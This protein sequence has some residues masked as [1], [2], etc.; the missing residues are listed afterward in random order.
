MMMRVKKTARGLVLSL[1][2]L[3]LT[4]CSLTSQ[5]LKDTGSYGSSTRV[6]G[7][8]SQTEFT[9][10][11]SELTAMNQMLFT[12]DKKRRVQDADFSRNVRAGDI[13]LRIAAAEALAAY[14]ELI[15]GLVSKDRS[16][17]LEDAAESFAE[18]TAAVLGDDFDDDK[19]EALAKAVENLGGLWLSYRR[20]QALKTIIPRY[21]PEVARLADYLAADLTLA[22][23]G[24]GLMKACQQT[25]GRLKNASYRVLNAGDEYSYAE[26]EVAVRAL[27]MAEEAL[28]RSQRIGAQAGKTLSALKK[29]NSHISQVLEE[30]E[31]ARDDISGY[32]QD[33]RDL[34]KIYRAFAQ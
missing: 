4:A 20:S 10:L 8:F 31:Y 27:V 11:R 2:V 3:Q 29:A 12:L 16:D 19:E 25:A 26:R 18:N 13:Q 22:D 15:S 33:I 17:E 14:G 30:K 21:Q 9:T 28:E 24:Q 6:L 23:G 34:V 1:L 32:A 7:E 5:Q